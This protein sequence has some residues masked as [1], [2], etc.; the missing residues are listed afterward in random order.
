MVQVSK[1][2]FVFCPV[3]I[4]VKRSVNSS[5]NDLEVLVNSEIK[6]SG[7]ATEKIHLFRVYLAI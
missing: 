1:A 3:S 5:L 4:K 7:S 6:K 2:I